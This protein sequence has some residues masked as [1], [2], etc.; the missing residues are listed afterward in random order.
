MTREAALED[1]KRIYGDGRVT[2][3]SDHQAEKVDFWVKA[4][5]PATQN[6]HDP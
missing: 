6:L 5:E 4:D 2:M 3:N 1:L